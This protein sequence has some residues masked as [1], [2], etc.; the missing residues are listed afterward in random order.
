MAALDNC[1]QA[2]S[3]FTVDVPSKL[4]VFGWTTSVEGRVSVSNYMRT[5][6][7]GLV[8]KSNGRMEVQLE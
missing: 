3:N 5:R 1:D 2:P 8:E 7:G 6:R 4:V